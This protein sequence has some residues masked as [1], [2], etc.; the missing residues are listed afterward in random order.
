[1]IPIQFNNLYKTCYYPHL[2]KKNPKQI[3]NISNYKF[4]SK[5]EARKSQRQKTD[6]LTRD[7]YPN[8]RLVIHLLLAIK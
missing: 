2:P 6:N 5:N 3:P 8:I 4:H 1:M 7:R